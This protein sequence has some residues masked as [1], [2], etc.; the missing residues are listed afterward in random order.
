[1]SNLSHNVYS[2]TK[3]AWFVFMLVTMIIGGKMLLDYL[4]H[5]TPE[6]CFFHPVI[7]EPLISEGE[8]AQSSA[9]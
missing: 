9:D 4:L 6:A 2:A 1:M 3:I 8:D 7:E 5:K